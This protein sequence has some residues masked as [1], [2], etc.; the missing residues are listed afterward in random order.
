M[1]VPEAEKIRNV[2]LVGHGGSGKTSMAE[3]MLFSTGS[4]SRL[5]KV[6]EG[7]TTTDFDPEEIKKKMSISTGL[8]SCKWEDHKINI[9]DTPGFADFIGEVKS[10]LRVT[11]SVV[12]V[13]SAVAGVEVQA[14][15]S[16]LYAN[17][18]E[19]PRLI[20]I[21]KMERE[22]ADFQMA[23][24]SISDKLGK[25]PI[26]IHFPIGQADKFKGYVDLVR[27]KAFVF[28]NS[29]L[30]EEEI[31]ADL[32]DQVSKLRDQLIE[33]V[34]ESDDSLLEKYLEGTELTAEEISTGLRAGTLKGSIVPILCGSGLKNQGIS[35]LLEYIIQL[36]PSPT[37][38]PQAKGNNPKTKSEET[39]NPEKDEPLSAIVFKTVVDPYIGKLNIFKVYS[40]SL[41]SD[42]QIYNSNKDKVER[43]GQILCIQG[44]KQEPLAEASVGDIAAVAKL[45]ETSTGD[46]LC[47][48]DNPI[49]FPALGLPHPVISAAIEPKTK[50]DEDKLST[51]LAR[52][53][54]EDPTFTVRRDTDVRQTIISGMGETHMEIIVERLKRKFG[55]EA[56]LKEPKIPY[57]ETIRSSVKIQGKYKKQT[58]GHGQYGDAW[59][60]MEPLP[61]GNGFEFVNKIFGGSIPRQYIPAVEK[62]IKEA[63]EEGV[64]GSYPVIDVK[65]TLYDGSYHPVDSSEMAF[66]IAGSLAFKN[67]AVK[68]NPVLLEPVVNVEVKIPETYMGDII[69]DLNSKR[70][71][72]LGVE[73]LGNEQIVKAQVPLSEMNKYA[74]DLRS[75]TQGRGTFKTELSHYEEVPS[76]ISQKIIEAV[77]AAKE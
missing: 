15:I 46:T 59:I 12:F 73:P 35:T 52:L 69:G 47:Q 54:E 16:W 13:L 33:S 77:K 50:G 24:N 42:S 41:S 23:L 22:N 14:E 2:A 74:N 19:L 4:I 11:D 45:Q 57:R 21:N 17:D 6:D 71:R 49:I 67:G 70:G 72:I 55:V 10:A 27:M 37:D 48:E 38:R 65:V 8:T 76:H 9:L 3:A 29:K 25:V 36:L 51:A 34:A 58:G 64:L 66:K 26:P 75:I 43:I 53:T 44:K 63:M 60:E 68:A 28:N 39:R 5:G 7:N 31:P 62:G 30:S 18:Y 1:K 40:G 20:F 61:R 56:E 32:Q